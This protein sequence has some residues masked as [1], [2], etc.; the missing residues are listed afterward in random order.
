MGAVRL[1]RRRHGHVG[2]VRDRARREM[3]VGE[4][5]RGHGATSTAAARPPQQSAA[6]RLLAHVS[7]GIMVGGWIAFLIVLVASPQALDDLW[8][9]VTDLPLVLEGVAWV[10][11]FPFLVGLAIWQASWAE[12]LRLV[13]IAVLAIAYMYMFRPRPPAR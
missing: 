7:F 11:G 6:A 4:S 12:A 2:R 8:T 1:P 9:A 5:R 3:V 13:A 10:L